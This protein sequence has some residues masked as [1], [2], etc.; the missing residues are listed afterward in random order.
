MPAGICCVHFHIYRSSHPEVFF[1]KV[2]YKSFRQFTGEQPCKSV[3]S[4]VFFCKYA[5]YAFFREDFWTLVSI[6]CSKY[7]GYKYKGF[8]QAGEKLEI[9]FNLINTF[10]NFMRD[11]RF[12]TKG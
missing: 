1:K 6:Y 5:A 8:L 4:T 7:R 9:Y 11:V 10:S 3:T 2:F 12:V